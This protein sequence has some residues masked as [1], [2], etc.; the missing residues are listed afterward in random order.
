[1]H[2]AAV[3]PFTGWINLQAPG[4]PTALHARAFRVRNHFITLAVVPRSAA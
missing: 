4:Y 2:V 1:M 3:D